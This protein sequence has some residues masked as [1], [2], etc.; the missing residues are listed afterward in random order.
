MDK[1]VICEKCGAMVQVLID[2]TCENCGIK[3]CGEKM[4]EISAEEAK[5]ILAK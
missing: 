1:I 3:C 5:K 4:K 2:C